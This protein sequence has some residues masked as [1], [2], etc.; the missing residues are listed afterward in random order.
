MRATDGLRGR[1]DESG[2]RLSDSVHDARH[3]ETC[4]TAHDRAASHSARHAPPLWTLDRSSTR[5][6]AHGQ[7]QLNDYDESAPASQRWEL[8]TERDRASS[9]CPLPLSALQPLTSSPPAT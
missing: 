8:G 5:S 7:F 3:A 6:R 2:I 1:E 4:E 9:S